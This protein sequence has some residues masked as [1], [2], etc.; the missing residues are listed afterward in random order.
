[1][2][3]SKTGR[4]S[5]RV[6]SKLKEQVENIFE[7]LGMTTSQAITLFFNQVL[8]HDGIPFELRR[9]ITRLSNADSLALI[10]RIESGEE[11]LVGPFNSVEAL[12]SS[13]LGDDDDEI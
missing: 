9:D 8:V 6:N 13:L 4:I 12:M 2:E 3:K 11:K 5:V 7:D 10:E 1:M